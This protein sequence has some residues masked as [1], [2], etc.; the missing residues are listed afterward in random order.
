MA[1]GE[2]ELRL[3][4]YEPRAAL[5]F[6]YRALELLKVAQQAARIYVKR[7]LM[8]H[9]LYS[10]RLGQP[11]P[12]LDAAGAGNQRPNRVGSGEAANPTLDAWFDKSA[13]AEP[14]AFTYGNSGRNILRA[15]HQWN[16]DASL[17]KRFA[18]SSSSRLEF[19]AEAFNLLNTPYFSEPNTAIDTAAGGRVT[20]TSNNARQL[21]FGLKYIF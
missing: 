1:P 9:W 3:R 2:A 15:D 14:T 11:S 8:Y 20:S 17:F 13:F 7:V 10:R 4:T 12:S 21:Q 18:L 19:R 6:E 5:P 16:V